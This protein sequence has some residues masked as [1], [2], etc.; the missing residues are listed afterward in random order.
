MRADA[1]VESNLAQKVVVSCAEAQG[2]RRFVE[3]LSLRW[4][5]AAQV[6]S[7]LRASFNIL[8][9]LGLAHVLTDSL[10]DAFAVLG[11]SVR[12]VS[13]ASAL[14]KGV[15]LCVLRLRARACC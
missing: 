12:N 7:C 4:C 9:S 6:A 3:W 10:G 8:G 15:S 13:V 11:G 5:G 14:L 1:R 2:V